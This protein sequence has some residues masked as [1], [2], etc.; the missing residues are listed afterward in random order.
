MM[1]DGHSTARS[2]SL[3]ECL[4]ERITHPSGTLDFN[5]LLIA[6]DAELALLNEARLYL[7]NRKLLPEDSLIALEAAHRASTTNGTQLSLPSVLSLLH[8]CGVI[9]I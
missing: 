6:A 3:I 8:G 4:N 7:G 1:S 5:H 9:F 2:R